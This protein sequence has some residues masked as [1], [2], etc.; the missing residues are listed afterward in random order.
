M[1]GSEDKELIKG[2]R[3]ARNA[4][5]KLLVNSILQR[6]KEQGF[7][8]AGTIVSYYS[9]NEEMYIFVGKDPIPAEKDGILVENLSK[10]RLHLKFRPGGDSDSKPE[11]P[12][13]QEAP[14]HMGQQHGKTAFKPSL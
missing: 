11:A 1:P 14:M 4:Q 13:K 6:M 8:V 3:A 10:N 12:P 9:P 2:V 5:G 7:N